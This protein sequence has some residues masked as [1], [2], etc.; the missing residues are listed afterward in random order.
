LSERLI[1]SSMAVKSVRLELFAVQLGVEFNAGM[2][3]IDDIWGR[4]KEGGEKEV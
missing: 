1:V 3:I 4:D 2:T